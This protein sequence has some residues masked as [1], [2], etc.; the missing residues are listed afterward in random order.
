MSG[1]AAIS[2]RVRVLAHGEGLPLP[3]WQTA[4]AVGADLHA[5]IAED[6][7]LVLAPGERSV[8][9]CGFCLALPEGWE[10][11]IRPRSGLAARHGVTLLGA[12]GTIDWDYR[13]EIQATVVNLGQ[14]P[15][16]LVRG[17]RFAQLVLAPVVRA[18]WTVV[19]ELEDTERGLQGFGSTGR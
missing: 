17:D 8:V 3:A 2:V 13:G 12:P 4:G 19:T 10:A 6:A 1:A 18:L 16:R 5:A 14:Q 9:P 7:P 11:Q 15:F